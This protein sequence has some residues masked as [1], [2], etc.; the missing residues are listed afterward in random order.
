M[1][2]HRMS[3]SAMPSRWGAKSPRLRSVEG[4]IEVT[5]TPGMEL[6]VRLLRARCCLGLHGGHEPA[7]HQWVRWVP[8]LAF[9]WSFKSG[10]VWVADCAARGQQR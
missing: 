6:R 2:V 3:V 9:L 7:R 8:W 1:K 5:R 10:C 4:W